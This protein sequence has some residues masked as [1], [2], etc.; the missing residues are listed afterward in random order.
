MDQRENVR[1]LENDFAPHDAGEILSG[2][3]LPLE[4]LDAYSDEAIAG[5]ALLA[6][7]LEEWHRRNGK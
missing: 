3:V 6:Q 1:M 5:A 7:Q 2:A 4:Y